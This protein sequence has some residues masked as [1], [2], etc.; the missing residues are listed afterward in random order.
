M[1]E[2][3]GK[4]NL[5]VAKGYR[6]VAKKLAKERNRSVSSLFEVLVDEEWRRTHIEENA[7][8]ARLPEKKSTKRVAPKKSRKR[9]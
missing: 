8:T 3:K 9:T 7:H 2:T 6:S 5:T 4:L 1:S